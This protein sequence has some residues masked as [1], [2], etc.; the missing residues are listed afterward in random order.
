[1]F[2]H[3][4]THLADP[5]IIQAARQAE[6]HAVPILEQRARRESCDCWMTERRVSEDVFRLKPMPTPGRAFRVK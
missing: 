1:M 2:W 6:Q 3:M 4:W 5:R